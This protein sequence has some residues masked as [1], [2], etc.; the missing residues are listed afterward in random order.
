M[1]QGRRIDND[2]CEARMRRVEQVDMLIRDDRGWHFEH[3][4]LLGIDPPVAEVL[5][6]QLPQIGPKAEILLG[7]D[8][9]AVWENGRNT[10][11]AD[12]EV[13]PGHVNQILKDR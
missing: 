7:R 12:W 6:T 10:D 9:H 13:L 4:R 2:S 11:V 3:S 5:R 1:K 8:V